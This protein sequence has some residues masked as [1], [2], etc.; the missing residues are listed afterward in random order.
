MV[1]RVQLEGPTRQVAELVQPHLER[2]LVLVVVVHVV[3]GVR[4][5][6]AMHVVRP[7]LYSES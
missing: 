6:V 2:F 1:G 7:D 5:A 3:L 4:K